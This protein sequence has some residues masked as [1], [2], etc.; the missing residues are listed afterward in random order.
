MILAGV[1]PLGILSSLLMENEG[2]LANLST[3]YNERTKLR[4]DKLNERTP[5]Q[6]L[7]DDLQ[8]SNFT[9]FHRRDD[10]GAIT[11]FFAHKESIRLASR[12][13]HVMLMDCTYKIN[14]YRL[15]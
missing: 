2:A 9:H 7:F 15:P 11:F 1:K 4:K 14:K 13:H 8:A 3:L 10:D 12:Y 6:A 5:I